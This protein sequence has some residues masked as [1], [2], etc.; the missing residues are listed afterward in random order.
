MDIPEEEFKGNI[1]LYETDSD[2]TKAIPGK[3]EYLVT[4]CGKMLLIESFHYD[5]TKV[6]KICPEC[7]LKRRIRPAR[8]LSV[9]VGHIATGK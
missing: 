3:G 1:H 7:R 9:L 4:I 5:Y 6:E 8:L 2:R